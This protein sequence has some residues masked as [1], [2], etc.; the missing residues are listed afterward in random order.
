MAASQSE[1]DLLHTVEKQQ[2]IL[3]LLPSIV[4]RQ[5][6]SGS[7]KVDLALPLEEPFS[8]YFKGET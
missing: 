6:Y 2:G 8:L 4:S 7:S 1:T 3:F 5:A